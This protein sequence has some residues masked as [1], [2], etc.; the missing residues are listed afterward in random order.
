[1]KINGIEIDIEEIAAEDMPNEV[2]NDIAETCGVKV[3][4][5]LLY[6]FAG[7]TIIVPT[8]G[9]RRIEKKIIK[10]EYDGSNQSIKRL[11]RKL[12]LTERNI[13]TILSADGIEPVVEGQL[14]IFGK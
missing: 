10:K 1:M 7:N 5:E 9:F 4:V 11:A 13:R 2:F 3:A 14:N 6:Y 8:K 12:R